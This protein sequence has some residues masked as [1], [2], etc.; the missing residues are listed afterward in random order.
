MTRL[1]SRM[2][3]VG[4]V[5][6]GTTLTVGGCLPDTFYSQLLASG[7]MTAVN[8]VVGA[9]AANWVPATP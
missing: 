4:L 2:R 7:I 1:F 3:W 6:A 8:T 9:I 5:L